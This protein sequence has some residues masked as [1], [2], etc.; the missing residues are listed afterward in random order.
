MNGGRRALAKQWAIPRYRAEFG[1][2]RRSV[3]KLPAVIF[4]IAIGTASCAAIAGSF[5]LETGQ[6]PQ[7][8]ARAA[9]AERTPRSA[10]ETRFLIVSAPAASTAR[11]RSVQAEDACDDLAFRFLNSERCADGRGKHLAPPRRAATVVI[12]HSGTPSLD[13]NQS[14]ACDAGLDERG[15]HCRF[16]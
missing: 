5:T 8:A 2:Q 13:V 4:G 9:A 16:D 6:P 7:K 14:R 10:I 15:G 11:K 3:R 1:A 12:A